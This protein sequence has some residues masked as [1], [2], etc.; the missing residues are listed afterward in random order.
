VT[1]QKPFTFVAAGKLDHSPCAMAAMPND[2]GWQS[3]S[4]EWVKAMHKSRLCKEQHDVAGHKNK[5]KNKEKDK[6]TQK[7][8]NDKRL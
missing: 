8:S 7:K 3:R 2:K 4:D 6:H 1:Q 5:E